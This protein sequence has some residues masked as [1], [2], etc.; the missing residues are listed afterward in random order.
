MSTP[1]A[2]PWD[3]AVL[4]A[5]LFAIDPVGSG[6]VALRALPGPVR[7]EWLT[8]T[9]ELL[10]PAAPMRRIPVHV[11]DNRLLGGLDLAATLQAGRPIAERGILAE[12]DGGT[13]ILA[14]AERVGGT[15]V[16]RLTATLDAGEVLL[17][18]DGIAARTPTRF[19]VI[20]IDEGVNEDEQLSAALLDRL[21]FHLNLN[22]IGFRETLALAYTPDDVAAARRL[23]PSVTVTEKGFEALCGTALALGIDSLRAPLLALRVTRAAAALAGRDQVEDEDIQAAARLVLSPR[24]T[25][26][27]M[28]PP[29]E[30]EEEEQSQTPEPP[31]ES[32][33]PEEQSE[34]LDQPLE[35][36]VLEAAQAA[37]PEDLL[38][39]LRLGGG[40]RP[41]NTSTGKAG[42]VQQSKLRGR[43][44][45]VHYGEPRGGA[46]MNVVET[47]R[48]AAPWQRIRRQEMVASGRPAEEVERVQVR[49]DDFRVTRFKH[50]S[51]T[52]TIFAVDASGSAA[53]HRL[54]EAKGAV[55]LL[56]ADCYVRRDRVALVA[57]RGEAAE[58]LLPP[59]RS[60]VRA[61]RSL[62]SL[63]GGGGTP[64]A[65]GIDMSLGLADAVQRRGGTPIIVVLTDGRANIARDGQGGRDQAREDALAAARVVR[66]N[67]LTALVVDTSPRPRPQARELAEEM[68]ARYLPLPYADAQLLSNAVQ[69]AAPT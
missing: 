22:G 61:K 47:L 45:G 53:L 9:R 6:G 29:P 69:A 58:L 66:A 54:A 25:V 43:P 17:E 62:A 35:D 57:F 14:M 52:T 59:T 26:I 46:R 42:M 4:A 33:T 44:A 50:R 60:L 15:T 1:A 34:T 12:A 67:W 39:Q 24:A 68:A 18:R 63:P 13:V 28:E 64:L 49:R 7:D 40:R 41:R 11:T 19:G 51:E 23:L 55:E 16:A 31:E 8:L 56:L 36:R 5:T 38:A 3:D 30:D 20:A 37:I 48:T 21:A 65:A 27:P 2:F 10:P 32:E